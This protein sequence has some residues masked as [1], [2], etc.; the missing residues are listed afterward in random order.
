MRASR[1]SL[2]RAFF[3]ARPSYAK[4]T[5]SLIAFCQHQVLRQCNSTRT[6]NRPASRRSLSLESLRAASTQPEWENKRATT[7]QNEHRKSSSRSCVQKSFFKT[8]IMSLSAT[9]FVVAR[10]MTRSRA[11]AQQQKRGIVDYLT[12]YPDKVSRSCWTTLLFVFPF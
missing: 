6:S 11:S 3:A 7:K 12:N 10:A 9:R 1:A 5:T 4:A 2:A 8:I